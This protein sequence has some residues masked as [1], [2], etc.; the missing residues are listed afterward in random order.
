MSLYI[1]TLDTIITPAG[2][3]SADEIVKLPIEVV[4][5]LRNKV[6]VFADS[7]VTCRI[8]GGE[9]LISYS[10]DLYPLHQH[11]DGDTIDNEGQQLTLR[12]AQSSGADYLL[13]PPT[14]AG[15]VETMPSQ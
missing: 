6:Q 12:I 15:A 14:L 13:T 2:V 5:R 3:V 9:C 4:I 1:R 11:R 7:F 10:P 8:I